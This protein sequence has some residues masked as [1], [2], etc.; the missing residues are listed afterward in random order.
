MTSVQLNCW[1]TSCSDTQTSNV[2]PVSSKK[3]FTSIRPSW[4]NR[5]ASFPGSPSASSAARESDGLQGLA[6]EGPEVYGIEVQQLLSHGVALITTCHLVD[7]VAESL[8]NF[9][10]LVFQHL[11]LRRFVLQRIGDGQGLRLAPTGK[12]R[13]NGWFLKVSSWNPSPKCVVASQLLLQSHTV[14]PMVMTWITLVLSYG[15]LLHPI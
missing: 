10:R 4:R 15:G 13:C 9:R 3:C 7:G 6:P 5:R 11:L 8:S 2:K 14:A 1:V 12:W